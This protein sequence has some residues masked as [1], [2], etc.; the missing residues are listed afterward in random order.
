MTVETQIEHRTAGDLRLILISPSGT[1]SELASPRV[2]EQ[3]NSP[4]KRGF[5]EF[6]GGAPYQF[7]LKVQND[8]KPFLFRKWDWD[9]CIYLI[10]L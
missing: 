6:E 10:I 9:C 2:I 7:G 1:K 3:P 4:L 8:G 5:M